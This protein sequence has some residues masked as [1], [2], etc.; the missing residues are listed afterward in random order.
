[1]I[2][3]F[4]PQRICLK[5]RGCCRFSQKD[6]VWLPKLLKEERQ[7]LE[8]QVTLITN[9][10]ENNFACACLDMPNNKCKIYSSRPFEC[11]LYPFLIGRRDKKVFLVADLNCPFIKENLN[12][13]K[14]KAYIQYL[15]TLLNSPNYLN[16]LKDNPQIIQNYAGVLDLVELKINNEIK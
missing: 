13:Q 11:Q 2:K 5:C 15:N 14:F 8:K 3:Q 9:A 4:V 16:L 12:N 7:K 10:Q 1:M 6:S